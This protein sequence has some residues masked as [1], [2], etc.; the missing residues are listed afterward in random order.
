MHNTQDK[1]VDDRITKQNNSHAAE[2]RVP[3]LSFLAATHKY[4]TA[5]L[6]SISK[7]NLSTLFC[8][9]LLFFLLKIVF[10]QNPPINYG[11]NI[12]LPI[13]SNFV[14]RGMKIA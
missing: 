14:F 6:T 10:N 12:V 8:I 11:T 1:T 7:F 5:L 13:V 3:P 4:R 2:N 9:F